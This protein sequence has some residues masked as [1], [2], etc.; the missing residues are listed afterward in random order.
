[1]CEFDG[2]WF[3]SIRDLLLL[4]V[5]GEPRAGI[6]PAT[7]SLPRTCSTTEPS[8]RV[9]IDFADENFQKFSFR[10]IILP[11]Q[12]VK[13]FEI[14]NLYNSELGCSIL[15]RKFPTET[16]Q[17]FCAGRRIRTFGVLSDDGFTDRCN[18]PL[19]HPSVR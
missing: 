12:N 15:N 13:H 11:F 18:C 19:C 3:Y 5:L 6:E 9:R 17:I 14:R 10:F 8:G 4:E 7:S 2:H 1:M 16:W